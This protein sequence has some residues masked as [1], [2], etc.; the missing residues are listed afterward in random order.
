MKG[1][2]EKK[3][4]GGGRR[5]RGRGRGMEE[6]EGNREGRTFNRN[7]QRCHV[8]PTDVTPC[9]RCCHLGVGA[10]RSACY[11]LSMPAPSPCHVS[12]LRRHRRA[13]AVPATT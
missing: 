13:L 6:E 10:C 3:G 9:P 5:R 1:R 12:P 4:E 8:P 2:E 7:C 11:M